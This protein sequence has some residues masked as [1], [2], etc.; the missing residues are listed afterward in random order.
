M[1]RSRVSIETTAD[2]FRALA[3][4]WNQLLDRSTVHSVFLTWD[5]LYAWWCHLGAPRRL[6]LITVREADGRLVGLAPFC[7]QREGT[8]P[9]VRV[10]TF[11]GRERVSSEYLDVIAEPGREEEVAE[12]VWNA[13]LETRNEWDL[14]RFEDMLE[15]ASWL[16]YAGRVANGRAYAR[17]VADAQIC[18]HLPLPGGR[19]AFDRG[20]GGSLR[21]RARQMTRY[22]ERA[23]VDIRVVD[24]AGDLP[25]TLED[26]YN[27]HARRWAVRHQ[28]GNFGDPRVRAFHAQVA[29]S[30]APSRRRV[31]LYVMTHETGT[32]AVLYALEYKDTLFYYQSGFDPDPDR[33]GLKPH[34]YSP[35]FVLVYRSLLDAID[36]HLAHYDFLRGPE[37]YK[38]RWTALSRTTRSLTV[39]PRAN[40]AALGRHTLG[41]GIA[42]SKRAVKRLL[43]MNPPAAERRA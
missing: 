17:E 2:G 34:E 13:L 39:V 33:V 30:L 27:L 8:F 23:S 9:S 20:L 6:H 41:R 10:A 42:A 25:R 36:R 5:W 38:F 43:R 22:L 19:D 12:D 21:R 40:R 32:L 35:G 11:L 4:E 29:G 16:R 26:L 37:A 14:L 3:E 7:I 18:P 31:R 28:A 1:S 15:S 24:A